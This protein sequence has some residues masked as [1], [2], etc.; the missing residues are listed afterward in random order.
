MISGIGFIL[1]AISMVVSVFV[2]DMKRSSLL[3]LLGVYLVG[4]ILL[5]V[6]ILCY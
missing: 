1:L 3:I 4:L 6:G 2:D 5:A